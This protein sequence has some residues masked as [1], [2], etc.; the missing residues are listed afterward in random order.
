LDLSLYKIDGA[1][2]ASLMCRKG[3]G[4]LCLPIAN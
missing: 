2:I 4:N 1:S 3:K